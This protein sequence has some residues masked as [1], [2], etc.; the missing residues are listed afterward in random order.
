MHYNY[1]K[2]FRLGSN[3]NILKNNAGRYKKI[4]DIVNRL[5]ATVKLFVVELALHENEP[6][7]WHKILTRDLILYL[8]HESL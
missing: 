5:N 8:T 4:I 7:Q 6:I 3:Y 1:G 2:T